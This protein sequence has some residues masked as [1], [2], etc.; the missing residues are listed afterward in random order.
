M[1][2][3]EKGC[4]FCKRLTKDDDRKNLILYRGKTAFVI[5]NKYPYNSGHLMV[6]PKRHKRDLEALTAKE[7]TELM[8]LTQ[9]CVQVLKKT[10]KP[11]GFNIGFNLGKAAGAGI[12]DHLHIHIV[13]RFTGDTNFLPVLGQTKL[14]SIGLEEVLDFLT[15]GFRKAAKKKK[16]KKS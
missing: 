2:R 6:V 15:P 3:K 12:D 5:L 7:L 14:Q 4:I 1:G 9:K 11:C 16:A 13:P 10:F 8:Q